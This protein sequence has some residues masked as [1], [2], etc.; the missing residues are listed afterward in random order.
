VGTWIQSGAAILIVAANAAALSDVASKSKVVFLKGNQVVSAHADGSDQR[1]LTPD[2]VP[3]DRPVW[4]P[5]G[6]KIAYLTS[7]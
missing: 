5:D 4:S 6:T 7:W 1:I 2:G 3:K